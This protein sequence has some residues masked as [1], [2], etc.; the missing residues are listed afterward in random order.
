MLYRNFILKKFV[1]LY[2]FFLFHLRISQ[3]VYA[4]STPM[5]SIAAEKDLRILTKSEKAPS[6]KKESRPKRRQITLPK[7]VGSILIV[8]V[9]IYFVSSYTNY[10][11]TQLPLR[12][13]SINFNKQEEKIN[14]AYNQQHQPQP[15]I[16][17]INNF[18]AF[19]PNNLEPELQQLNQKQQQHQAQSALRIE[20]INSNSYA[21]NPN[22]LKPEL[23]LSKEQQ[24]RIDK[25]YGQQQQAYEL[26]AKDIN[27]E[28]IDWLLSLNESL[29]WLLTKI[30]NIELR[31]K[32]E[33]RSNEISKKLNEKLQP[34]ELQRNNEYK[35]N[36]QVSCTKCKKDNDSN[37]KYCSACS[38]PNLAPGHRCNISHNSCSISGVIPLQHCNDKHLDECPFI[39]LRLKQYRHNNKL[40][41]SIF[42]FGKPPEYK[43]DKHN[44]L[45][46][47]PND[48]PLYLT[49]ENCKHFTH[50]ITDV[51]KDNSNIVS[52]SKKRAEYRSEKIKK[53]IKHCQDLIHNRKAPQYILELHNKKKIG[54]DHIIALRLYAKE[55]LL[56]KFHKS[57]HTYAN[58]YMQN[59]EKNRYRTW[60]ILL[61]EFIQIIEE[62]NLN[63][64]PS[65]EYYFTGMANLEGIEKFEGINYGPLSTTTNK[66]VAESFIGKDGIIIAIIKF[67]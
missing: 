7:I 8:A 11:T 49:A 32:I 17:P 28:S 6:F 5:K 53:M 61:S 24:E 33:T 12:I 40:S 2:L 59:Q 45:P 52:S 1:F 63:I 31:K 21:F 13:E 56:Q 9:L 41:K 16:N 22:N 65:Q 30:N 46:I 29:V 42:I 60:A 19:N 67:P 14:I 37:Y 44:R 43:T 34:A 4:L 54:I 55:G 62:N 57:L 38:Y 39:E 15:R 51:K 48:K 23:Q 47:S 66:Q 26:L 35:V 10:N 58:L 3:N 50:I 27:H 64:V 36:Q 18:N 20:P 25:E